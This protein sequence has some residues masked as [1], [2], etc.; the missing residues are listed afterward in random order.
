[1]FMTIGDATVGRADHFIDIT[2]EVCPLTFVKTRLKIERIKS[3][4]TLEVRLNGGEPLDNVPRSVREF[5]HTVLSQVREDGGGA[6][7]RLLIRKG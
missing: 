3:G 6:V 1:M 5:G 2:D 4:E 7:Y